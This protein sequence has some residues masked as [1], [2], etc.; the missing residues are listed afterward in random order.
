MDANHLSPLLLAYVG[1]AVY[2]VYVRTKIM[3]KKPAPVWKLHREVI[4]YVCAT[5]QDQALRQIEPYLSAEEAEIVRRGRNTKARV[6]K[7]V[8]VAAYRRATGFEALCGW[9]YLTE[10]KERLQELLSMIK[11]GED[12]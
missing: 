6:P 4:N 8:D 10:Q 3:T 9:L 12:N 2:E 7:N 1:D 5:G 11:I